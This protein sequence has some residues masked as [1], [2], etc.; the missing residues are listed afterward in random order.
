MSA[1][2]SPSDI[3]LLI[4]IARTHPVWADIAKVLGKSR[5]QVR[6]KAV[7]LKLIP[8]APLP[9]QVGRTVSQAPRAIGPEEQHQERDEEYVRRLMAHGGFARA[10]MIGGKAVHVWPKLN[11]WRGGVA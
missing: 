4:E 3:Q 6:S 10:E 5:H 2:W 11:P 7:Q 9:Q 1:S 8:N